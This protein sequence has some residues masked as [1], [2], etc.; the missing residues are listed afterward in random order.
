MYPMSGFFP[1]LTRWNSA[2][3]NFWEMM[4]KG[5]LWFINVPYAWILT[6]YSCLDFISEKKINYLRFCE[7]LPALL[8]N[9]FCMY[10]QETKGNYTIW[11]L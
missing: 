9:N 7:K 3:L 2:S 11:V 4:S 10:F 6:S 5:I 1:R 8:Q